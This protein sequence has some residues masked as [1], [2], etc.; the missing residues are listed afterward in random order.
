[1]DRQEPRRA[2]GQRRLDCRRVNVQRDRIDV[3][4]HRLGA[5]VEQAV[6]GRYEAER[7]R[8]HL[9]AR[10]NACGTCRQM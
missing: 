6:G 10:L 8:D 9:V 7:S 3:G 5:L 2:L 1:V 4:E